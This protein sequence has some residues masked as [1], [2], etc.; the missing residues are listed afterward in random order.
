MLV[1]LPQHPFYPDSKRAI[2]K[3]FFGTLFSIS[4][5]FVFLDCN[6]AKVMQ[7][8]VFTAEQ[9]SIQLK[10]GVVFQ[11]ELASNIGTGYSWALK[12]PIDTTYL[13][14]LDKEYFENDLMTEVEE[15]KEI[16]RFQTKKAGETTINLIYKRPWESVSEESKEKIFLVQISKEK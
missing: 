14:F 5:L 1:D 13:D 16:W 8:P 4:C 15:S 2:M 3:T 12:L 7:N 9:D 6:T 10:E 11:L